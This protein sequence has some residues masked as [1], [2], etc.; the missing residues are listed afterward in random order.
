MTEAFHMSDGFDVDRR[1]LRLS[2]FNSHHTERKK[3][4][5]ASKEK[6]TEDRP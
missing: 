4:E 2:L 1:K 6:E 3:Q 5:E